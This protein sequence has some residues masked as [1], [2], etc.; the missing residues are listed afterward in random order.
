MIVMFAMFIAFVG[1]ETMQEKYKCMFGHQASYILVIGMALSYV[2]KVASHK[3]EKIK[4]VLEFNEE[5]FF[6]I[7]LPPII[8]ASGFNMHRG[9]FFANINMVLIL[10]VLSTMVSFATFS[11]A[12]VKLNEWI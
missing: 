6:Y 10:G 9:D 2:L 8:F 7:C 11:Y 3:E 4:E 1:L 12:S 5:L